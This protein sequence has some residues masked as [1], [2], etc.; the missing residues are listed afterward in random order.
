MCGCL[1][2]KEKIFEVEPHGYKVVPIVEVKW[3]Q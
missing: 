3:F 2:E 1:W